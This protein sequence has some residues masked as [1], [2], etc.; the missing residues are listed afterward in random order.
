MIF[1]ENRF[2]SPIKSRT[3]LSESCAVARSIAAKF[4]QDS[5]QFGSLPARRSYDPLAIKFAAPGAFGQSGGDTV[6]HSDTMSRL[7]RRS[8]LAAGAALLAKPALGAGPAASDVDVVIIG[9]GASG[10]AAARRVAAAKQRFVVIEAADHVGGR[11]VTDTRTFGVPFDR[12]AHWIHQPDVNPLLKPSA[13]AGIDVYP[14]PRGQS[15]RVGPRN[16]RDAELEIFLSSLV[17]SHRAIADAARAKTDVAAAALPR[18]LGD[19]QGTIEFILGPYG[20][21]KDLKGVSAMDLARAS[22]RDAAAFCRQ[23]Y[24]ALLARLAADLPV[25]LS[26][27]VTRIAWDRSLEVE[28][29]KGRLSPRAIIVTVSTNVLTANKIEFSPA[30]PKRQLDAAA[31]LSLGSYDHIA[32]DMPGNPLNL[33]RDDMVFEQSAGTRTAALLANISGSGLHLVEIGAQFGRELAV[34]GEAA[35]V[36]FAGDWLASLFGSNVKRA[37]KRSHATRWNDEPFVLGAMS[38]ATVGNADARKILMESIGGRVWFAG[39][40][41]HE[42][43]PGTVAGAWESGTRAAESALR[44]LGALKEPDEKKEKRTPRRNRRRRRGDDDE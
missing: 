14:A 8:F 15:V 3:S 21:G 30:L 42:T 2:S 18:D 22:E 41:V 39:E 28:T 26:T 11:C 43:Q 16:A 1:S 12:G 17:R 34:K 44:K 29:A 13:P 37:I 5:L 9:A 27:P 6:N 38:A 40:A 4:N 31:K 36:D 35:M 25:R 33:Q 10:I 20:C 32:L 23:G 7:S 24:G 19:W